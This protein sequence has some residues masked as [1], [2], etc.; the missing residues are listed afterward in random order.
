MGEKAGVQNLCCYT[1]ADGYQHSAETLEQ[2]EVG[3]YIK[4][5]LDYAS[6]IGESFTSDAEEEI[7]RISGGILRMINRI[8]E[9]TLM[10]ANQQQKQMIDRHMVRYVGDH[11][12]MQAET[13]KM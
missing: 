2:A 6:Y 7:Y 10:Y 1:T 9:K 3:K 8:C 5:H 12:L 13:I 11:E 4:S